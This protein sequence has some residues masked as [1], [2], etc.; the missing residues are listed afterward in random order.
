ML[1]NGE[2]IF[3]ASNRI[4]HAKPSITLD[5][6]GH[7][8]SSVQ[9]EIADKMD[10]ILSISIIISITIYNRYKQITGKL[11]R[12]FPLIEKYCALSRGWYGRWDARRTIA[13]AYIH[14]PSVRRFAPTIQRMQRTAVVAEKPAPPSP[15]IRG[16]ISPSNIRYDNS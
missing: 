3:V 4:G 6:Y 7:L 15:L 1:N 16:A 8:L 10:R 5:V 12:L 9:N 2:D 13:V 14:S 11:S